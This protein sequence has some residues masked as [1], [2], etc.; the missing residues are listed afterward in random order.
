MAASPQTP[1]PRPQPPDTL[2]RR[3]SRLSF[4]FLKNVWMKSQRTGQSSN[5]YAKT[6]LFLGVRCF[7]PIPHHH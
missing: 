5:N 2:I 4:L 6:V 1:D 3:R 7:S